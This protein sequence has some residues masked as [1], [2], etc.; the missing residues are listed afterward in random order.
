RIHC[1]LHRPRLPPPPPLLPYT[2]LFR[3]CIDRSELAT[4]PRFVSNANRLSNR[5]ALRVEIETA[6][7]RR[8]KAE[9]CSQLMNEGIPAAP[10]NSVPEALQHAHARHRNMVVEQAGYSGL[11]LPIRLHGSPG[12]P[13]FR[14]PKFDEHAY[15]K[16]TLASL[17]K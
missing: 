11:G 6:F 4:D 9:L 16:E 12:R 15:L 1:S 2:T 13:A 14:A 3:S 8:S 17:E 10:V 7:A 5:D